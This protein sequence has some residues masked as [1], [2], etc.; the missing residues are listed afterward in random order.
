MPNDEKN[1]STTVPYQHE[2]SETFAKDPV[3]GMT[4][5]RAKAAGSH[6]HAGE[7]YFFCSSGC[8]EKFRLHPEKY[9]A[10]SSP[11]IPLKSDSHGQPPAATKAPVEYT[12]PMHPEVRQPGPG[13]CLK[14]GMALEPVE[15]SLAPSTKTEYVCPMHPEIV[16][17]KPGSCPI[18]GMTLEPRV[19]TLEEDGNPELK[20]MNRRFWVSLALSVPVFLIS[21]SEMIPG[22][23]LQHAV[24]AQVLAWV[25]FALATPVVIWGGWPF[26]QRGW[27]SILNR[28]LNMFTLIAMGTGTAYIYSVIATLFPNIFPQAFRGHDGQVAVYFEAAAVITTLVLLGQVLELKARSQT[29]SAIKALLGLAPKTARVIRQDGSEEDIALDHV[30]PGDLLRV[31]PGEKVPVDGLVQEGSSSVDESMI[32]GESIP[33]EKTAGKPSDW[34]HRQWDWKSGHSG[35]TSGKRDL[36]GPNCADGQ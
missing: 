31:R 15:V 22:Q 4:I 19:A 5:N 9:V 30:L 24:S 16:R 14:C 28:N 6:S 2:G 27:S 34:R 21:M 12:C 17:D 36:A 23:P 32:T 3:C 8:L 35:R 29:S 33:V 18:C 7:T 10:S 1:H 11:D 25:Q 13:A 20:D 26:F